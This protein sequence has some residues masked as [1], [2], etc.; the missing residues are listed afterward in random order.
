MPKKIVIVG[1]V[2]GGASAAARLRRLD[3]SAEIIMFEKGE[4]ISFANCGLPYYVSGVINRRDALLVQ[5]PAAMKARFNIDVRVLSE[6]IEI[7]RDAKEVEIKDLASGETYRECYDVLILSPGA[8]PIVPPIKGADL[9]NVFTVRNIPDTDR[10]KEWVDHENPARAVVVGGGFIGLEMAE[11]LKQRGLQV[12]LVEAANQVMAPLDIEM[13]NIVHRY[14]RMQGIDLRLNDALASLGGTGQVREVKLASGASLPADMVVLGIG[15][16]P[17]AA[18]A[19]QAG[20]KVG[21]TGGI[22]VDETLRTSDPDIYAI[23]DA[24]Q[25]KSF[26]GGNETLIPLAGP[27][28]KQGRMVADIIC[29]RK[30]KYEGSLGTAIAKL[31]DLA[32]A[33]TG[34]NEKSLKKMERS[35]EVSYTHPA[36]HATYYPGG[37]NMSIKLIFDPVSGAI[38]GSQIV[39][40]QG[41]DKRIDVLATSIRKGLTV[42][43][44]QELELAY[45]PPFSS[46][47]DPVN[48][49]GYVAGNIINGDVE[50]VQWH[51][52][53]DL[54]KQGA[55]L[56]DVRTPFEVKMGAIEGSINIP[57]DDIRNNLDKL[58]KE[59]LLVIYCRVGLRGYI[60][61]RILKQ[62]GYQQVKNLSGGYLTYDPAVNP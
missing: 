9:A 6:V 32:V 5:T 7:H 57:V 43:D 34:L 52:I 39:G 20:L 15:V 29:G 54:K 22:Q 59:K 3:E 61:A 37:A 2:A 8:S 30:A 56:V 26:V 19:K 38:L 62:H 25:V 21:T 31:F 45:A 50:I 33:A 53:E 27:A 40:F 24:I 10:I 12:V 42:F 58:P 41:V 23:G 17:E 48:M 49:A 16:R 51:Q 35:Y 4:D 55:L 60:A 28:N 14:L 13:A 11:N 36:P 1:G 46:A 47:K 18:L 44:L